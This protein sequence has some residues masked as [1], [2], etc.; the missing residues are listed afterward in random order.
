MAAGN[1]VNLFNALSSVIAIR[2]LDSRREIV[3]ITTIS[4][5]NRDFLSAFQENRVEIRTLESRVEFQLSSNFDIPSK[6]GHWKQ[7]WMKF[8]IFSMVDFDV[9][10]GLD[11]D[12]LLLRSID[13]AFNIF[14]KTST[15]MYTIAAV[16]DTAQN[17][18]YPTGLND[19]FNGGLLSFRPSLTLYTELLTFADEQEWTTNVADQAILNQ[20]FQLKGLW[21]RLPSV[22]NMFPYNFESAVRRIGTFPFPW[23]GKSVTL[24]RVHGLHFT[25]MSKLSPDITGEGCKSHC[26]EYQDHLASCLIWVKAHD[27]ASALLSKLQEK[28]I[29]S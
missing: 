11:S 5:I 20:F 4:S 8:Y 21:L 17:F 3:L 6:C 15:N 23:H 2:K 1:E 14:N 18:G 29:L 10:V 28:V 16:E 25:W 19:Y 26:S 22:F 9:I 24:D 13:L 12:L 7:C 27:E